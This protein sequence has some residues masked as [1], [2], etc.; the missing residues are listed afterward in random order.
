M[1]VLGGR[2]VRVVSHPL[3]CGSL[4]LLGLWLLYSTALLALSQH[5]PWLHLVVHGHVLLFGYLFT[6]AVVGVDPDPHRGSYVVRSVVLVLFAAGHAILAKRIYAQPPV[7]VPTDQAE[8]GAMIM[9]YG[10]DVV[11]LLVI[12]LLCSAWY[13]ATAPRVARRTRPHLV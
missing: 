12:A 5:T 8:R 4:N 13:A 2:L 11:E 9:Y 1:R 7:G 3:V 6:A 10:G